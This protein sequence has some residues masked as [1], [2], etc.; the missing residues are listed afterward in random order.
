MKIRD[1]IV[2]IEKAFKIKYVWQYIEVRF[3]IYAGAVVL[4][5]STKELRKFDSYASYILLKN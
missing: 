4:C 5:R 3:F 1:V 2:A